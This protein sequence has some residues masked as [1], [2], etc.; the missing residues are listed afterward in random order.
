DRFAEHLYA[1]KFDA[2]PR[3][4]G[5]STSRIHILINS[6]PSD[7]LQRPILTPQ[8]AERQR[9]YDH[10]TPASKDALLQFLSGGR[11]LKANSSFDHPALSTRLYSPRNRENTVDKALRFLRKIGKNDLLA[12]SQQDTEAYIAHQEGSQRRKLALDTL[13]DLRPLF[14]NLVA[15][16]IMPGNPVAGYSEKA[17]RLNDDY[18]PQE[19]MNLLHDMTTVDWQ[20]WVNVE[21]RLACFGLAYDFA[22]RNGEIS[23]LRVQDVRITG[24]FVEL[25]IR[26]EIQKG[27]DK[28]SVSRMNCFPETKRLM[29]AYLKLRERTCLETD[30]LLI[31]R[32][33]GPLYDNGCRDLIQDHC[34]RLGVT[35]HRG[36]VPSTHRFR[37]SFGTLNIEPLGLKLPVT[38]IMRRLRHTSYDVTTRVYIT[39]NPLIERAKHEARFNPENRMPE[40]RKRTVLAP[41]EEPEWM[42]EAEAL[43]CLRKLGIR[44]SS[45]QRYFGKQGSCGRPPEAFST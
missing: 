33:G 5:Q 14:A 43:R 34:R 3:A 18:V 45:L 20:D 11:K 7:L 8:E 29:V 26:S 44:R 6:L 38:D 13:V 28:P 17:S 15:L 32:Q 39:N 31:N 23:R 16:G 9:R 37:H 21:G 22:L 10:L 35:T 36:L 27:E 19:G 2:S 30:A 4:A 12:V 41:Q 25:T 1:S 42:R 40:E 24:D